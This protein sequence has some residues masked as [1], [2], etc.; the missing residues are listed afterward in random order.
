MFIVLWYKDSLYC[1]KCV[2]LSVYI[3]LST[4]YADHLLSIGVELRRLMYIRDELEESLH[5]YRLRAK[6]I[7]AYVGYYRDSKFA[8]VAN[9]VQ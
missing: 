4:A 3:V 7:V 5:N 6:L 2:C 8:I 9:K 1:M